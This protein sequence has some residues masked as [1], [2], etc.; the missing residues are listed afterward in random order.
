[1]RILTQHG[2]KELAEL[3]HQLWNLPHATDAEK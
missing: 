3:F 2:K 1:M